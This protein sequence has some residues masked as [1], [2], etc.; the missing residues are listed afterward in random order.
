[1]IASKYF[2]CESGVNVDLVKQRSRGTV[3]VSPEGRYAMHSPPERTVKRSRMGGPK[4]QMMKRD[5]MAVSERYLNSL[6]LVRAMDGLVRKVN[7]KA[8]VV[9]AQA[10]L[11]K[12][13][14]RGLD[15]EAK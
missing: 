3:S 1:M 4:N 8:A 7:E 13:T 14:L 6:P 2:G 11:M 15:L 5:Q 9:H 10:Y 12:Y